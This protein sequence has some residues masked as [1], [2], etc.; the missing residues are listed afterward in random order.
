MQSIT[1]LK[2]VYLQISLAHFRYILLEC[3][4]MWSD[5]GEIY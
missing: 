5:G 1:E 4:K 2:I 3:S